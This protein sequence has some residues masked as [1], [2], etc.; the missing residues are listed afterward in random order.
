MWYMLR[1]ISSQWSNA[2]KMSSRHHLLTVTWKVTG[3]W[4]ERVSKIYWF[5]THQKLHAQAV[6]SWLLSVSHQNPFFYSLT[7]R[8]DCNIQQ[9]GELQREHCVLSKSRLYINTES[10]NRSKSSADALVPNKKH[11]TIDCTAVMLKC[12]QIWREKGESEI[13]NVKIF[14]IQ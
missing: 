2:C 13:E 5:K 12:Q 3:A 11:H 4:S 9:E 14:T 7:F 10:A 8:L 1:K 6:T